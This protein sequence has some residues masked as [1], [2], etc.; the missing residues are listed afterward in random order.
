[1]T[2][3]SLFNVKLNPTVAQDFLVKK[4]NKVDAESLKVKLEVLDGAKRGQKGPKK[5]GPGVQ[6]SNSHKHC[7]S[8]HLESP[9]VVYVVG[10]DAKFSEYFLGTCVSCCS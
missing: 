4:A 1:M 9:S 10:D 3:A 7:Q 6:A 8:I 2:T 5:A